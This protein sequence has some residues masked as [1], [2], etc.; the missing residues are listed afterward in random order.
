MYQLWF[1]KW[2][3]IRWQI[4]KKDFINDIIKDTD[5]KYESSINDKTEKKN[6]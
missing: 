4:K 5:D 1:S 6:I 2:I 3:T